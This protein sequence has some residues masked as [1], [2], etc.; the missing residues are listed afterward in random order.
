MKADSYNPTLCIT[1]VTSTRVGCRFKNMPDSLFN[2][3]LQNWKERFPDA[4]WD[5]DKRLWIIPYN[6]ITI[7]VLFQFAN[8]FNLNIQYKEAPNLIR[9]ARDILKLILKVFWLI[10]LKYAI[11][12]IEQWLSQIGGFV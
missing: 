2:L 4:R 3:C 6:F 9:R 12:A 11:F 10:L 8:D 5:P 7:R 1:P